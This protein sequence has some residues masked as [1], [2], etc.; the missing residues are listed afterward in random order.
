MKAICKSSV[1]YCKAVSGGGTCVAPNISFSSIF[2]FSP[3]I[4]LNDDDSN[5]NMECKQVNRQMGRW[6]CRRVDNEDKKEEERGL[7]REHQSVQ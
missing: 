7:E 1:E 5:V 4:D 3:H 6:T 2:P